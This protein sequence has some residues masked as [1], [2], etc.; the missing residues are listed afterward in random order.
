MLWRK[1]EEWSMNSDEQQGIT[2][3]LKQWIWSSTPFTFSSSCSSSFECSLLVTSLWPYRMQRWSSMKQQPSSYNSCLVLFLF[4]P[5]IFIS[6]VIS[7]LGHER[8]FS[9]VPSSTWTSM[10][11]SLPS[12]TSA[13]TVPGPAY[14]PSP[15]AAQSNYLDTGLALTFSIPSMVR[16]PSLLHQ[17]SHKSTSPTGSSALV[18][19]HIRDAD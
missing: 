17:S 18:E 4:L 6:L 5:L 10:T 11:S 2:W 8:S 16:F 19:K 15:M 9:L 7:S 13:P 14:S 1:A 12:S 3:L